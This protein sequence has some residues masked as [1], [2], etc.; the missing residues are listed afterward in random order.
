MPGDWG[1]FGLI[2]LRGDEACGTLWRGTGP[3]VRFSWVLLSA[4]AAQ[5]RSKQLLADMPIKRIQRSSVGHD[6]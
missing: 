2:T 5:R 3:M 1:S 6:Q 4:R